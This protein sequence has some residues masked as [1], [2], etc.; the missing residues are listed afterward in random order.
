M[1]RPFDRIACPAG[2]IL[3]HPLLV[4]VPIL[5]LGSP[6]NTGAAQ[7]DDSDRPRIGLVLSG[8][9]ARGASHVGVLKVL[10]RERIPIDY[11]TGT[12]MG[13]IVG[14]M[15]A[16]GMSPEEIEERLVTID[17]ATIFDDKIET[18]PGAAN[19][20]ESGV[21]ETARRGT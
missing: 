2:R 9:G 7:F 4:L 19:P 20:V 18:R 6:A 21:G 10:E 17:W 13:S 11:I 5:M 15:Y 1:P 16:A 3:L 12:S 14:G 8:G